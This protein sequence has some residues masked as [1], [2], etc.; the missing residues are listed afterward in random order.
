MQLYYVLETRCLALPKGFALRKLAKLKLHF[1]MKRA[2]QHI[3]KLCYCC[4]VE[5][6]LQQVYIHSSRM[7]AHLISFQMH[8]T[9]SSWQQTGNYVIFWRCLKTSVQFWDRWR[10]GQ[11]IWSLAWHQAQASMRFSLFYVKYLSF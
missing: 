4:N 7:M 8:G 6:V 9:T 5:R 3:S 2:E 10:M 11:L 1:K